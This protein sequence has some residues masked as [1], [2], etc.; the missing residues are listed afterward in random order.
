MA[1][2]SPRQNSVALCLKPFFFFFA[3]VVIGYHAQSQDIQYHKEQSNPK[4]SVNLHYIGPML[5]EWRHNFIFCKQ[6]YSHV[7]YQNI[8]FWSHLSTGQSPNIVVFSDKFWQNP[9][10]LFYVLFYKSVWIC[11]VFQG[12]LSTIHHNPP[13]SVRLATALWSMK[14]VNLLMTF[15]KVDTGTVRYLEIDLSMYFHS[16]SSLNLRQFLVLLS[17]LHPQCSTH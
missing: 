17:F 2:Y 16:F 13:H 6:Q 12:S 7:F 3:L 9:V 4:T 14:A 10:W 5:T 8:L 15:S 1:C 11:L